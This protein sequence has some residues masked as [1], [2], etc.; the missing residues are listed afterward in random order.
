MTIKKKGSRLLALLLVVVTLF[1]T[2]AVTA[3]AATIADGSK[4]VTLEKKERNTYLKTTAGN[5]IGGS[6]YKYTT[7]DGITGVGY[8]INW[9]L[10]LTSKSLEITGRYTASPKTLGAFANGYPQRSL[11]DFLELYGN[12]YPALSGLTEEE[13]LYATQVAIWATLGQLGVEGTSFTAGR[14]TIA[15]PTGG[16]AQQIR[17]Y[18]AITVILSHA[19]GW[20]K[21]LYTGMYVSSNEDTLDNAVEL[22][23]D[24]SLQ[25]AADAGEYGIEIATIGGTDYFVREFSIASAT[26]TWPNDYNI[27]VWAENAPQGTI[28]VDENNQPLIHGTYEGKSTYLVP[29]EYKKTSRNANDSEYSGLCKIA[30]PVDSAG[31]SG[32][33]TIRAAGTI[34]QFDIYLAYNPVSTEQSYIISDPGYGDLAAFATLAWGGIETG[35]GRVIIQKVDGVGNA[36]AGAEFTLT[37]SDGSY[38]TGKTDEN[39]Q[40]IWNDLNA[41]A[42][43]VLTETKAPAGYG[44]VDAQNVRVEV[45]R[46]SYIT[47]RNT[48]EKQLTVKKV[49]AQNGYSLQGA[50]FAFEQIDGSYKTTATTGHDGTIQL[51]ALELPVGSYR[52]YEVAAPEGYEKDTSVQT[53][54]W[55]AEKDITLYFENVRKPTLIIYKEDADSGDVLTGAVFEVYR[56]GQL[57]TTVTTDDAGLAYVT[58]I[59]E[60]F[61]QVK[62]IAAPEG[63]VV[64][65]TLHGI[66]VD[67]YDPASKDDPILI[68]PNKA[69]PSLQIVKFDAQSMEGVGDVSFEVYRDTELIGTYTTDFGGEIYISGL[70]PGTYLVKEI[71]A[72]DDYVVNSTPQQIELTAGGGI[73]RLVFLNYLKPGMHLVKLDSQTMQ[74]LVNATFLVEKVGGTFSKEYTTDQNGEIDLSRLEPGA[75]TVTETKAPDG[76]LIDNAV[77]TIQLNEGENAL[78]VFT[79]TKKPS[80]TVVKYDPVADRYLA[81]ATFRIAKIEDGSHYLDRVTDVNGRITIDNLDPGIYSVQE[82]AAPEG[83]ILNTQEYHMELFPGKE[84]QLVV[85]NEAKPDLLIVK[86]DANTGERL[87]GASFTVKKAD[88]NTLT[89]VTTDENGQALLTDM[90]TGAYVIYETVAPNGYLL[91]ENPQMITLFPNKTGTAVF[92]N[93]PKPVLTVNKIDSITGDPLKG[94]QFEVWYASNSTFSGEINYLGKYYTDDAGQFV[95]TGL[96]DGWYRVKEI[97][98]PDGYAFDENNEQSVYI[99]AGTGKVLTFENTP[100]SAIIIKKVDADT[101]APLEGAHFRLRYLGGTS[102]TGG[103]VI[104]EYET[105]AHGT[106]VVTRLKA[107]TYIVEEISAPNGYVV[108]DSAKTVY[109]SGKDQDVITVTFGNDKLGSLLIVKKDAVTGEPLSDVEFRAVASNGLVLGNRNGLF[110]TDSSG[111]IK[112]DD[113]EPGIT[114]VVKETRTVSGYVLDDTPQSIKIKANE[115]VSLEFR[116]QPKGGL[117]IVKKDAVTG[118]PLE[119]V[120]FTI[121]NSAGSF[122]ADAE[123]AI[124][125]NGLYYTDEAG[126]I[127]L[128]K[129]APDTY[130]VKETAT[131]P[132]YILDS[133]PQTVAVNADDT[134]TLTFLNT[135]VG[136]MLITK[137]DEETGARISG[138]TF[139]VRKMNGEVIGSY[140]TDKSGNISLPGLESGWYSVTETKAAGGYLLEANPHNIEVKDGQTAFLEVT[141]RKSSQILIHKVDAQTGEGIYGATFLL[142]DGNHTPIGQYTTD[143]LGYAYIDEGLEDGRYYLREIKAPDG[144]ILDDTLKTIHIRYGKTVEVEW[145]NTAIK[146]QIQIIKKSADYNPVSGLP[147]GSLLEGAVF[148]IYD[149]AGNV[150]DTVRTDRNGRAVSKLLPLSRYTIR[151]VQAPAYYTANSAQ[152]TAYLEYSGQIITFEVENA[153]ASTGVSIKKTGYSEVMPNSPIKYT[154]TGV[155]NTGNVALD[156][157]YWRDTL[158][159]AVRVNKIVTGTYSQAQ[160]Y[161]IVYK[162][163]ISGDY[164]TLADNLS[165][166]KNYVLDASAAALGL[167]SNEYITEVMFVFGTARAGF[168]QVETPMIYATTI[169]GLANK[170]QF[171]NVADVGGLHNGVWVQA[172]S[173]WVTTV[174]AQTTVTLPKTGY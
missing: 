1:S 71:A 56:D 65:S 49:D 142:Y 89:T 154:I 138:V 42:S 94:A 116:N 159:A 88:S 163:N 47:V 93:Y 85:N 145:E 98:A 67:P 2:F 127:V 143:Q 119:G 18:T 58:G 107:G 86:Q 62:E 45:N 84:S 103:T 97:A 131:I 165:T 75:Y 160:N 37:G 60:G 57:I 110:V 4:S 96:S 144:Y 150:V 100:L 167:A 132:G 16:T 90:D 69:K 41:A 21:P 157:F 162:T 19:D 101:G 68:I 140:T 77:R 14:A 52:V 129:L 148:E 149:K 78:F 25:N 46:T 54:N 3:Q 15:N 114:V 134:Q 126:M 161:K 133:T 153:S 136:G 91:N 48:V 32:S 10:A 137:S 50:V 105:S 81:G 9:G 74:P 51:D 135:P 130:V 79:D 20:T 170:S 72:T 139:E 121:T 172:V 164:R 169:S 26:S 33:V 171:V 92:E 22:P 64:D 44:I 168:A 23:Y 31:D 34:T 83:Y 120:T 17:V 158:P 30:I 36:L 24:M 102:G 152:M 125:S 70:E 122:V 115:T 112:I 87:A 6:G 39:G 174:Y 166:A 151:E 82:V 104:G 43:Y 106:I 13:F 95:L 109:L 111:T 59:S 156:S 76:Y 117:V 66:Y 11:S 8:C 40:I 35:L 38:Y 5:A 7:N 27:N 141:N 146:G 73:A 55:T 108:G 63:Y 128:T 123:G 53:V 99:K 147:A 61:Y 80:L 29:T 118:E 28:F 113:L 124:S 12:R 155:G 173:R